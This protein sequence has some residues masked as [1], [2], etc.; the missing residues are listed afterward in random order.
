M[1][2]YRSGYLR[3]SHPLPAM[4]F[5]KYRVPADDPKIHDSRARHCALCP[6]NYSQGVLL[7][8]LSFHLE[9]PGSAYHRTALAPVFPRRGTELVS[10]PKI[11]GDCGEA[12]ADEENAKR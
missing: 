9:Q 10:L 8:G 2:G 3:C 1:G 12:N 4:R 5:F 11:R 7:S 6:E